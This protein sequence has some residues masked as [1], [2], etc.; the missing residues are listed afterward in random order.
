MRPKCGS[1]SRM[2]EEPGMFQ[3]ASYF[4]FC[5]KY[6]TAVYD[7]GPDSS[8]GREAGSKL[9]LPGGFSPAYLC[10][11]SLFVCFGF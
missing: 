7:M 1:V 10:M 3:E 9:Y 2:F 11:S 5:S 6:L 8:I 4:C